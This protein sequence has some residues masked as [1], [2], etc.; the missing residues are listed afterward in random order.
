MMLVN[1]LQLQNALLAIEVTVLGI[2]VFSQPDIIRLVAVSM[3]ALQ[4]LRES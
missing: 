3:I 4:L 2:T 1:P